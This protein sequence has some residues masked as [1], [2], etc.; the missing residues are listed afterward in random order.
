MW[1]AGRWCLKTARDVRRH[2]TQGANVLKNLSKN[3]SLCFVSPQVSSLSAAQSWTRCCCWSAGYQASVCIRKGEC[4]NFL[5]KMSRKC[6]AILT[7]S[8]TFWQ[9]GGA[10]VT[11]PYFSFGC[12]FIFL[13]FKWLTYC[14]RK[15]LRWKKSHLAGSLG[16]PPVFRFE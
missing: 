10:V 16:K 6:H 15:S 1:P 2:R 14:R 9:D 13:I 12:H 7:N 8:L 4:F 11:Q 3:L 5:V